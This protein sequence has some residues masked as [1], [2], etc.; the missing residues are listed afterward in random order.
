MRPAKNIIGRALQISKTGS[1]DLSGN[2]VGFTAQ[3]LDTLNMLQDHIADTMDFSAARGVWNFT[4]NPN[5][6]IQNANL[7]STGPNPLPMDYL[8]VPV[9][10]GNTGAQ[11][12]S[13]WYL[14]GVPYDMIEVDLTEL[15]D[16]VQQAGV[17]SYPYFWAK[18]FAPYQSAIEI[19]A[20][21]TANNTSVGTLAVIDTGSSLASVLDG[22]SV[23][24]GFGAASTIPAGTT[25]VS[26]TGSP[27]TSF[28][29]SQPP[30]L[31][32]TGA[33]LM[34]GYPGQAY[35]YPP[36]S[37]AFNAMIRYQR[38]MPR[39]TQAQVDAGAYCWFS[40]DEVLTDGLAGLLMGF[41]GDTRATEYIGDGL[42][43]GGGRFGKAMAEYQK[44][45]DER[46]N[47]AQAVQLDR[48][49]FGMPYSSLRNTKT[50][51]W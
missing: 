27:P 47:R 10:G 11:R 26:H 5:L 32:Q 38:R 6:I 46:G 24:G 13:K 41:S 15:D 39:L 20:N 29:L 33:T 25:I 28:V 21:L 18:D 40:N 50:V 1:L 19:T 51:G 44:L 42:R 16:Q 17:Q 22:M 7:T 3:A 45:A 35:A 31:T 36:P 8:R 43:G 4:L 37:G 34:I 12:S 14:Q 2:P 9:S 48:R 49:S 30:T 23:S